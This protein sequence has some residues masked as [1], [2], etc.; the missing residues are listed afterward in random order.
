[1][2]LPALDDFNRADG[3]LGSNWATQTGENAPSISSNK[4]RT[5]LLES[6]ARWTADVFDSDHYAQAAIA[7][8]SA[9]WAMGPSTR[10]QSGAQS[11]YTA[12]TSDDNG[13]GSGDSI[14]LY[15][16]VAGSFTLLQGITDAHV[17]GDVIRLETQGTTLRV[18]KTGVQVGTNTTD[19]SLSGGAA[20]LRIYINGTAYLDDWEGGNLGAAGKARP[21]FRPS[22]RFFRRSF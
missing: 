18:Y 5:T 21:L 20:G 11:F 13:N 17:I 7:T 8:G 15:R 9:G 1:M 22:V 19:S 2:S 10:C 6:A 12:Q 16:C 3:G 14:N 4:C